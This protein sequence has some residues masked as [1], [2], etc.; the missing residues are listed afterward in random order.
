MRQLAFLSSAQRFADFT[1]LLMRLFVGLFLVW[2]VWGY[3]SGGERLHEYADLLAKHAFPN[4][5]LLAPLSVY[6]Q[7]AIGIAFV[8]GLFTRWAGLLCAFHFAVAIF[9]I[10]HAGGMR[11]TFPSGCLV[12]MGL[13]LGTHGAGR[14]SLDA[15]LR[16]NEL[17]R[18]TGGVRLKK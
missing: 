7:M 4:P 10:D 9:M 8:L 6:L 11:G 15:A 3:I 2:S 16:A 14:L 17:P 5:H 18:T 1:L 13:Y 12:V